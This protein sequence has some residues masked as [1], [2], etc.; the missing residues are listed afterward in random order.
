MKGRHEEI[1]RSEFADWLT[2]SL[3]DAKLSWY[4]P[5]QGQDHPDWYLDLNESTYAVEATTIVPT[6]SEG[7]NTVLEPSISAAL[8][9]FIDRIEAKARSEGCL[10]GAYAVAIGPMPNDRKV[11][12]RVSSRI[13]DFLRETRDETASKPRIVDRVGQYVVEVQKFHLG[14]NYLVELVDL[15]ARSESETNEDFRHQLK[16]QIDRKSTHYAGFEN[17]VLLLLLDGFH[18]VDPSEWRDAASSLLSSGEFDAVFRIKPA[19]KPL[20]LCSQSP[21]WNSIDLGML[22]TDA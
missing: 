8:G 13:L 9:D 21:I 17:P 3:P 11:R 16:K 5:P 22:Q 1:A 20:L 10:V 2:Q 4:E 6:I 15:P 12:Q 18:I 19:N 7:K 14:L